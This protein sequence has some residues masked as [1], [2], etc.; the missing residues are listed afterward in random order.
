MEGF[1]EKEEMA[2]FSFVCQIERREECY[3]Q[4]ITYWPI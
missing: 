4:N 2:S 3:N 1:P